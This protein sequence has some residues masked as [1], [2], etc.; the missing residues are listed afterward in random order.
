MDGVLA[1]FVQH[2]K[3]LK[4]P[5]NH[6]WFE[7][8]SQWTAETWA[9]EKI[10]TDAMHSPGFWNSL[11]VMPGG[12]ELWDYC[13]RTFGSEAVHVLTCQPQQDSPA[14]VAEE[15]YQWITEKLGPLSVANF[16]C[17]NHGEKKNWLK[18]GDI[19]VDDDKRHAEGM[20]DGAILV[21]H[22][23]QYRP[24]GDSVEVV[25]HPD[26]AQTIRKLQELAA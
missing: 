10:K 1:D 25:A 15:K 4:I 9:G 5:N 24:N 2:T 18:A 26:V 17:V 6:Q 3:D 23:A 12:K 8:K 19:L 20:V 11:P 7:P 21:H 16:H 22:L 14:V 13:M